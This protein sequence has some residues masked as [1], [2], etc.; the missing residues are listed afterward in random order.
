MLL[1]YNRCSIVAAP[2]GFGYTEG[3]KVSSMLG[4]RRLHEDK[5][6]GHSQR[7]V[8]MAQWQGQ[9]HSHARPS[10]ASDLAG[11]DDSKGGK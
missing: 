5:P 8:V 6:R 2:I 4:N 1:Q 3:E 11:R 9:W 10:Q 7:Q